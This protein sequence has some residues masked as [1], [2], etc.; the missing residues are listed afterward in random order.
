[1]SWRR[2]LHRREWGAERAREIDS[3][4]EMETQENLARG[5]SAEEARYAAL[6]KFG[7]RR[8]VREEIYAMNSLGFLETLWQDVRYGV[9]MLAKTPGFALVAV[10]TLALG[11]GANTAIF[12]F[13]DA[14]LLQSLPV[15]DASHLVVLQWSAH[16]RPKRNSS[17]SYG[18][19]PEKWGGEN[20]TGC[21]L[22]LPF[23]HDVRTETNVFSGM[24]AFASAGQ[25]NLSG[26]GN[27][28][29]ER[30]QYVSGDFFQTLGV[31]A[32]LG[33]TITPS[34]DLATASP[35]VVLG[36][37]YWKREFGAQASAVGKTIQLNGVPFTIVGVVQ[38]EFYGVSPG[39]DFE[40]WVPL[41]IRP[42]MDARHW[43]ANKLDSESS[44]WIVMVGHLK[45]EVKLAQAQAAVSLLFRNDMLRGAKPL[46]TAEDDPRIQLIPIQ[47]GLTGERGQLAAALFAIMAGVGIILLI[48]CANVA[49]LLLARSTTRHKEMAVRLALGA[50]RLRLIRQLLTESVLLSLIGGTLGV[51]LA[52]WGIR[53]LVAFIAGVTDEPIPFQPGIDLAVLGFTFGV[54]ILTGILFGLAPALR[55][56]RQDLTPALKLSSGDA[57]GGTHVRRSF[58][59]LGNVLVV[60]QVALSVVVLAGAGLLVRTLRN[61]RSVDPGF[62]T[63]NVLLFGMQPTLAGYKGAQIDGLY[64]DLYA[65]ISALPGVVSVSYSDSPL[66][67]GSQSSM[68]T[69]YV[70]PGASEKSDIE[71]DLLPVSA[72]FFETLRIPFL[73][74]RDLILEDFVIQEA[75]EAS[76]HTATTPTPVV[77]NEIFAKRY[78]PS[79]NPLG[80]IF[81]VNDGKKEGEDKDAGFQIVGVVGDAKY[82]N[83]RRELAATAYIPLAASDAHFEVRTAMP[84][85]SLI[86]AVRSVVNQRDA[87]L[88]LFDIRTERQQIDQQLVAERI[89]VRISSS[90]GVLA[91]LLACVGLYGLLAYEV[92]RRTREIGIRIALGAQGRD[93]LRLVVG[94]GIALAFV[95]TLLGIAA[96][97]GVTRLMAS[98]LY[99]VRPGDPVTFV[100]VAALLM[101]IAFA[102]CWI[103]AR[104][105]MHVDP[106]V[107]LRYE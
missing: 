3:Y 8:R 34:D 46:L 57:W 79:V 53:A 41:A 19:C 77:V 38:P 72:K 60:T 17:S 11:I 10:L 67:S 15:K 61:L 23:L 91:L 55:A 29:L 76:P 36:Y 35:A 2:F 16:K 85:E 48:A 18:D 4:V 27:A 59:G 1:M 58:F 71:F 31:R 43:E 87:N 88:P 22:S 47:A 82:S 104:R 52:Y 75:Y 51:L 21:S 56:T 101:I 90:V 96:A 33:R 81:G 24:A 40:L 97:L 105:A 42:R 98:V 39:S 49:G 54:S 86:P 102:A 100:A 92:A 50:G 30:G 94:Q 84:P 6:R 44:W 5:M 78:Y 70:R 25:L 83:L 106:I 66:L 62:D 89:V 45:P 26:H 32:A 12:S 107:A 9:R 80:Q 68:T 7:N 13:L 99:G 103:P 65:R 37:G 95:G 73:A 64:R 69:Q 93:V 63:S 74:G 20:P 28:A 14:A